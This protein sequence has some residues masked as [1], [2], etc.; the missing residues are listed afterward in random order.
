MN[1]DELRK[2]FPWA[3]ECFIKANADPAGV[4]SEKPERTE[5]MPLVSAALGKEASGDCSPKRYRIT[6]RC[7]ATRPCDY[8]NYSVK[9]LQD[10]VVQAGIIPDDNW[11][12]LEGSVVSYKAKTKAEERTIVEIEPLSQ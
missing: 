5:G 8:D 11:Q 3:S 7:F 1:A 2:R 9:C 4:C 10:M 12:V 6:F